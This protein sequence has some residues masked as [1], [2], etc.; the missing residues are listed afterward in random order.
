MLKNKRRW[1]ILW[2]V[3]LKQVLELNPESPVGKELQRDRIDE[4]IDELLRR[5]EVHH[6]GMIRE[7]IISALKAQLE[8]A[9]T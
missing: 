6:P 9:R 3:P 4:L 1:L 2:R 8:E 5:T 7:M